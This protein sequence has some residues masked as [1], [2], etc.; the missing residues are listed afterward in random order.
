MNNE[1][2]RKSILLVS[3]SESFS[4][5]ETLFPYLQKMHNEGKK[6]IGIKV[7]NKIRVFTLANTSYDPGHS[8]RSGY[9]SYTLTEI[10]YDML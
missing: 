9:H 8:F 10:K 3:G 5:N 7:D 6:N 1:Q 4:E 2:I